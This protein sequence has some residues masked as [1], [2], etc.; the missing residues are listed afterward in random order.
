MEPARDYALSL[1]QPRAA[2][3]PT[4]ARPS[5]CAAGRPSA[6]AHSHPCRPCSRRARQAWALSRRARTA[7][8]QTGGIIGQ[9][10][11]ID[12]RPYRKWKR[13]RPTMSSTG[14]TAPGSSSR[15]SFT[16]WYLQRRSHCLFAAFRAGC[17]F[18]VDEKQL[19]AVKCCKNSDF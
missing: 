11:L 17:G 16:A 15:P 9:A 5:R 13:F 12:C 14:T 6:A 7:A 19:P 3:W 8:K 2:S 4:A 18:V 1:K 10:E